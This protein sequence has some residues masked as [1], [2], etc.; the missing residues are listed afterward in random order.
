MEQEPLLIDGFRFSAVA[1]GIKHPHAERLDLG[2]IVADQPAIAAGVFTANRVKAAPVLICLDRMASGLC[3]AILMN[4][5]N[6]NACTGEQGKRVV[7]DLINDLAGR[8]SIDP[9]MM[10]P[11]S[12]GVIGNPFPADRIRARFPDLKDGLRG[13]KLMDVARAIMTTD[14]K[15][16]TVFLTAEHSRGTFHMLGIA[17]GSGMI[18]PECGHHAHRGPYRRE[19]RPI[20]LA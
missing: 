10:L 13:D 12:T 5:G 19:G 1:A 14:T 11:M 6:A 15:P 17:K 20:V 18:A 7:V 2:L 16:K 4:S 9:A 8:L 3:Q